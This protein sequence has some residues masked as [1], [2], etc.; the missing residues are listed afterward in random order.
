MASKS[1]MTDNNTEKQNIFRWDPAI[2]WR[3]LKRSKKYQDAVNVFIESARR[4]DN[5][6]GEINLAFF[7]A[8]ASGEALVKYLG[9]ELD[10]SDA[11]AYRASDFGNPQDARKFERQFLARVQQGFSEPGLETPY[12]KLF[13]SQFGSILRFPIDPSIENECPPHGILDGLWLLRPAFVIDPENV[14]KILPKQWLT[15]SLRNDGRICLIIDTKFQERQIVDHVRNIVKAV[16]QDNKYRD[17]A[18]L[19]I[20]KEIQIKFRTE[21]DK[22]LKCFDLIRDGASPSEAVASSGLDPASS[23][24]EDRTPDQKGKRKAKAVSDKIT[25]Y[26][27]IV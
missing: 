19:E 1:L 23:H 13:I 15:S 27:E 20:P 17:E 25:S 2:L 6:F 14:T 9:A 8:T 21:F 5:E 7:E 26:I 18:G 16:I 4:A 24:K 11:A 22:E 12:Q 10:F 3:L